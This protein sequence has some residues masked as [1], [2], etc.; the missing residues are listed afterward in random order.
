[1]EITLDLVERGSGVR[2]DIDNVPLDDEPTFELLRNADT[3]GVFQLEGGPMRALIRSLAPSTFEDVAALVALYRPGPMAANMHTDYADRKNG[4]KPV[5]FDHPDLEE[6]LAP[7][8]GLMIYQEQLM[9]VSQKLA[10]YTLEEADNLRKATGKKDRVLIAKERTKFVDGCE[11]QGHLR[12]FGEQMFDIIEPFADYSFNKSHSVGYGF[13]AYQ[14]AYLKANHPRE[15]LAAL[16]TSVKGDKDKSA[17]YLNECRQLDI[18]VLV[19]DVNE[20]EMDFAVVHPTGPDGDAGLGGEPG[21]GAIRFGLSAVRNVGEGVVAKIIE[22]R[23]ET[24]PFVDFYDF[25]ERVAAPVLNKRT[26]ESLIKAGAFDSLGHPRQGLSFVFEPII[27]VMID[28]KNKEA[29]GQFDLFSTSEVEVVT[30]GQSGHAP[31]P[32][33]EFAKTQRLAFEKEMLGLY[34]SDHPLMG[35]ERALRRHTD[36]TLNDLKEMREGELRTVGGVVTALQ[37]KYTKRGDLMATF[38]LEDLAAA[39]EVMVFPKTMA[40]Y[41]EL[42]GEDA[43]VCVRGRLDTRDDTPKIIAMEVSAPDLV[44]DGAPPVRLRVRPGALTDAKTTRLKE[45]LAEHPGES[46]VF[47]HLESHEKTTVVRLG[48]EF[49]VSDHNG[50]LAELRVLLGPDCVL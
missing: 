16:L 35:A 26:I 6:I 3:I 41:G 20:S 31:I 23:N 29:E 24:G 40:Q 44:L 50:L 18:P 47:V 21:P 32:D 9:R 25:C 15:Y 39:V 46:Q 14:T 4:R 12:E 1:M 19:P 11:A 43:I 22:A 10:G 30:D 17:I 45:I 34:V 8:F 36:A 33:Q 7:T 49:C 28:R 38:V 42:L 37:K 5:Q 27:D 2:P 13:V 48:D